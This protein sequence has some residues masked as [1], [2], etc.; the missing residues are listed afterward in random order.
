MKFLD[1]YISHRRLV[2]QMIFLHKIGPH[3]QINL[4]PVI[5]IHALG[6]HQAWAVWHITETE[7]ELSRTAMEICPD[8]IINQQK[9]LEW[10]AARAM[11]RTILESFGAAYFGI[12][13]NEF[14]KPFLK[15]NPHHISLSHSYPYVMVQIDDQH[16]IGV[17]LEQPKE[18]LRIVARRVFSESEV[19]DAANDL[20]KLCIYWCAKEAL[21]KYYGKRNL[22]FTDHLKVDPFHL[23][24]KGYLVGR[25]A[26]DG[27]E[28][29]VHLQYL[30]ERDY[31]LVFTSPEILAV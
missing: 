1:L 7:D 14:G 20:V 9:R 28:T 22:L 16:D 2:R 21:Y 18:K 29:I 24:S 3:K 5:K 23:G 25:I 15:N 10:T 4:M 26:F 17:D 30:V 11:A 27:N 31:V 19:N 13:K 6:K 8:K 12:D